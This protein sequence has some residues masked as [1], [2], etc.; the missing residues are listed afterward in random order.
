[1]QDLFL[2]YKCAPIS[3]G[4]RTHIEIQQ[5]IEKRFK[6]FTIIGLRLNPTRIYDNL[7]KSSP[8]LISLNRL[9]KNCDSENQDYKGRSERHVHYFRSIKTNLAYSWAIL[10]KF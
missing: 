4:N 7:P 5:A 2:R 6:K 3:S 9:A 1:M 10:V 8:L